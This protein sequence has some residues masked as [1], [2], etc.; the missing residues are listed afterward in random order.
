MT[1]NLKVKENS[2]DKDFNRIAFELMN[3]WLLK[4]ESKSYRISE[5]EFYLKSDFHNDSYTHG[6]KLQK[7]KEKWYFH[8]SG[9]DITFGNDRFYGGILIRAIY[10]FKNDNYIY[11]PL[12]CVTEVFSNINNIYEKGISFGLVPSKNSKIEIENPIAAPRVG[13]NTQIDKAKH[14]ALYRFLIMPKYKHA[15]KTKIAEGMKQQGR[16]SE[17]EIKNIWG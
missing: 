11:G 1:L 10:D 7:Q 8:G 4:I 14:D 5:I 3:H 12:N 6:H 9:V 16:Y 17:E 2:I 13:L 15:E